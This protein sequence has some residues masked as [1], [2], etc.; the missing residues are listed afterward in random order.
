MFPG[1]KSLIDFLKDR[2]DSEKEERMVERFE[3]L[4]EEKYEQYEELEPTLDKL[5]E[6]ETI[7]GDEE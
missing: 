6:D 1:T 3:E 7:M 4:Y 5:Q 2:I